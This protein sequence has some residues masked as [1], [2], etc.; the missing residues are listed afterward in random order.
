M[1]IEFINPFLISILDILRTMAKLEAKPGKPGVKNDANA[2]GE[3]TGLIGMQGSEVKGSLAVTFA[4]STIL[5]IAKNMVG[6]DLTEIDESIHD[7]VGE[8]TNMVCGG[9]KQPLSDKG[10]DFEMATPSIVAGEN[11]IIEHLS[12]GPKIMLPFTTEFGEFYVEICF[13]PTA[14]AAAK[15][16]PAKNRQGSLFTRRR[17][18]RYYP[19]TKF[20]VGLL[21]QKKE[22]VIAELSNFSSSGCLTSLPLQFSQKMHICEHTGIR[23]RVKDKN[24]VPLEGMIVRLQ[25]NP[26]DTKCETM[27]AAFTFL[28]ISD[29]QKAALEQWGETA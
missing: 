5:G 10:Y 26:D 24:D 1:N 21:V 20:Q 2:R 29:E 17:D 4:K 27:L 6:D 3:I 11:H 25:L 23:L 8:I 22:K 14:T 16:G 9:A 12:N 13:E 7:M 28:K 15:T 18:K 19:Q